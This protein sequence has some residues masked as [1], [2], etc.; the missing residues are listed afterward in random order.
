M[1]HQTENHTQKSNVHNNFGQFDGGR[2]DRDAHK[3]SITR[4]KLSIFSSVR[5]IRLVRSAHT[6][7]GGSLHHTHYLNSLH[8]FFLLLLFHASDNIRTIEIR[9]KNIIF[10][11]NALEVRQTTHGTSPNNK[12]KENS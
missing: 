7:F 5:T 1:Q 2:R 9:K 6:N 10:A 8:N 11:L 3:F 4:T 12:T